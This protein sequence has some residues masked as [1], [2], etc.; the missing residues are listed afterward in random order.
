MKKSL[1]ENFIFCAVIL[2]TKMGLLSTIRQNI[3]A[4]YLN[5]SVIYEGYMRKLYDMI[6]YDLI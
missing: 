5:V 2:L 3:Y 1:K 4:V 6:W